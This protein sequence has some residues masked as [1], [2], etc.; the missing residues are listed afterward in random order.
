M[1]EESQMIVNNA[2]SATIDKYGLL[3]AVTWAVS[4]AVG[5]FLTSQQKETYLLW[6]KVQS[7]EKK[8]NKCDSS[9]LEMLFINQLWLKFK[10][11][12]YHE[13]PGAKKR[14]DGRIIITKTKLDP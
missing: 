8:G 5:S 12:D 13:K 10:E 11:T 7:L 4:V 2:R 14:L 6:C 1:F 9:G 3:Y